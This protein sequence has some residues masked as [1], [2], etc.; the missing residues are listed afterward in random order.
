M[1]LTISLP[2]IPFDSRLI[3]YVVELERL[4]GD[5][6]AGTTSNIM[7]AELHELFRL[8]SSLVSAR[9]EG[10]RTTI[11]DAVT[12]VSTG[13]SPNEDPGGSD[14]WREIT[15]IREAMSFIDQLDPAAPISHVALREL[16]K[17]AVDGLVREGDRAPGSYRTTE[18]GIS[19]SAHRPPSHVYLMPELDSLLEFVNRPMPAHQQLVHTAIAHHRF[20]WIH[21]FGNG[22]GRVSRLLTYWMLRRHGYLSKDGLR[23]VNPAAVFGSD[24]QGYYSALAAADSLADEG[25]VEW[26]TFF[27]QGMKRD[28]SRL[29]K[30]QDES[31]VVS[32]VVTPSLQR[33][34][35]SGWLTRA[36][37]GVLQRA[38]QLGDIKAGDVADLLPGSASVRSVELRTLINRQLLVPISEGGRIYRPALVFNDL[39]PFIV[40]RLD[41]LDLVPSILKDEILDHDVDEVRR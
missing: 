22:N 28:L 24:R 36:H 39:T 31:F 1:A 9:I 19:R 3:E 4:R 30:L 38:A 17:L 6:A 33:M 11:Y 8:V 34:E 27:L 37:R 25:V 2:N 7:F 10:N 15:N 21:P 16:H 13:K 26:A 35:A 41:Q 40:R 5:I 32:E 23:T 29:A 18:V 12:G 20:L 14:S